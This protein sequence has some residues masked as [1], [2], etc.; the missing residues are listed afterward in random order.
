[1]DHR[2]FLMKDNRADITLED[3]AR[4]FYR[5]YAQNPVKRLLHR[6][7]SFFKRTK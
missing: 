4:D 6:I 5:E 1:M 3:A 2:W 7:S